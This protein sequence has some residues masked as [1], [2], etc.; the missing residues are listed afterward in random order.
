LEALAAGRPIVGTTI[1]LEGLGLTHDREVLVADDPR[2]FAEATVRLLRDD[3]LATRLAGVG[4]SL[5]EARYGWP[6]IASRFASL[7]VGG[8]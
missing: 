7:V 5:V 2:Q 4:R 1:G 6:S 8:D 3:R